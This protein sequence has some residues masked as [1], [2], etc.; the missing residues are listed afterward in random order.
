MSVNCRVLIQINELNSIP[1]GFTIEDTL[2]FVVVDAEGNIMIIDSYSITKLEQ[3]V[4]G[5]RV[6]GQNAVKVDKGKVTF[7][8]TIFISSPENKNVEIKI[9]STSNNYEML[10]HI[11]SVNW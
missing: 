7:T 5:A 3:L 8:N 9:T 10:E 6:S 11:D 2:E 1:S 4:G